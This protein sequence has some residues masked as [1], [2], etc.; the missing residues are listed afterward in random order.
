MPADL[1]E[2]ANQAS[3]SFTPS[4][5]SLL[6]AATRHRRTRAADGYT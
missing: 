1:I 2:G 5:Q 4:P 6:T 3:E